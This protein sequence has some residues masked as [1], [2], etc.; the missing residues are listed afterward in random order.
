[1]VYHEKFIAVVK[2]RGKILRERKDDS[3][4]VYMP[5]GEEYSILFKNLNSFKALVSVS[6]DGA[7]VLDGHRLIVN[8]NSTLELERFVRNLKQ[9]N[10]FKF[11]RKTE[12]ISNHRGDF[13][14]DG[15]IRIEYQFEAP[16]TTIFP[17]AYPVYYRNGFTCV[18][19]SIVC[20]TSLNSS[21]SAYYGSVTTDSVAN[22]TIGAYNTQIS[23]STSNAIYNNSTLTSNSSSPTKSA[24]FV[25][26]VNELSKPLEDEGITVNGSISNQEFNVGCIGALELNK[27][28]ITLKLKVTD[29]K[30]EK[31]IKAPLTVKT[32][33]SCDSC[34]TKNKSTASFCSDCGTALTIV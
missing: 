15:I 26:N 17:Y 20:G 7:D 10:K 13:V 3:T 11:I 31:E 18:P 4:T 5:F 25:N 9:G 16:V 34:G 8:P 30:F 23:N 33:I 22:T 2:C 27:Y 29:R 14:D 32:K 12:K 21:N 28:V 1:M 24:N 6:I 19:P